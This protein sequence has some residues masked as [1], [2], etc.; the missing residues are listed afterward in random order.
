MCCFQRPHK[1]FEWMCAISTDQLGFL[2][3]ISHETLENQKRCC[4]AIYIYK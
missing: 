3:T 4:C 2:G 1:L